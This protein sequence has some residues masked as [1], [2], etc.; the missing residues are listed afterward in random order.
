MWHPNRYKQ[1]LLQLQKNA[2]SLESLETYVTRKPLP[3]LHLQTSRTKAQFQCDI[4]STCMLPDTLNGTHAAVYTP[5]DGNCL[6]NALSLHLVGDISMS[7]ELRC[8]IAYEII[9]NNDYYDAL[10]QSCQFYDPPTLK[11]IHGVCCDMNFSGILEIAAASNVLGV[12]IKSIYPEVNHGIRPYYHRDFQPEFYTPGMKTVNIMFTR[13]GGM[14]D[15][16]SRFWAPNHF[17]YVVLA[18]R[19]RGKTTWPGQRDKWIEVKNGI[20]QIQDNLSVTEPQII[21]LTDIDYPSQKVKLDHTTKPHVKISA[22]T[23][24]QHAIDFAR[25]ALNVQLKDDVIETDPSSILKRETKNVYV[26]YY[27]LKPIG[28]GWSKYQKRRKADNYN[29]YDV[30][31]RKCQGAC[32][33]ENCNT[34]VDAPFK[35]C[36][37]GGIKHQKCPCTLVYIQRKDIPGTL[38][39]TTGEHITTCNTSNSI[40]IT[41]PKC[42]DGIIDLKM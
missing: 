13:F 11:Y 29:P 14:H 22:P 26:G 27:T 24:A 2:K 6:Y 16:K 41:D 5:G 23:N 35:K 28:K 9:A 42:Y 25:E 20:E 12:Q 18:N 30:Y 8:R 3:A 40:K 19:C 36:C 15:P 34:R 17:S 10:S 39:V 4:L 32:Y 1:V 31:Y 33:C 21:D 38:I 37:S 7:S